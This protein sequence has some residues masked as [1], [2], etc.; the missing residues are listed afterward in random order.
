MRQNI[1]IEFKNIL[2]KKEYIRL[3]KAFDIKEE[4]IFSHENY[5]FDTPNFDLKKVGS[6][7]RIRKKQ[8]C[9]ELTLKQPSNLGLLETTQT[10]TREE[11][12]QAIQY[13]QL[14][15]GEIKDIIEELKIPYSNFVYFGLLKTN[16]VEINYLNGLLVLDHSSYL[17][18]EDFEIELEVDN[19]SEGKEIFKKLLQYY[20]IPIRKTEN[21]IQRFYNQKH[22]KGTTS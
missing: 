1:E 20:E 21:K 11:A 14:P 17:G 5:Y 10:L 16:R 13:N 19:Y 12:I 7:L 22:H 2:T 18:K 6:A 9:F 4:Q 15:S 8:E 3:L